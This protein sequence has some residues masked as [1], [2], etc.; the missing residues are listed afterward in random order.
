MLSSELRSA[1]R[2]PFGSELCLLRPSLN[3]G[4][5]HLFP[6]KVFKW[7]LLM[8]TGQALRAAEPVDEGEKVCYGI[9]KV[10]RDLQDWVQPLPQ[11]HLIHHVP[12]SHIHTLF[13]HFQGW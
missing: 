3:S 7:S 2:N 8:G 12:Q 5:N 6:F 4:F 9:I 10:G 11:H 13:E 1:V